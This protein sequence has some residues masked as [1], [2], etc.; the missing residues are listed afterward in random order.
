MKALL[1]KHVL[2]PFPD[3]T[4]PFNIYTDALDYQLN[5]VI[6][7]KGKPITYCSHKP[8]MPTVHH[9]YS[10]IVKDI[11]SIIKTLLEYH[12]KLYGE[13][14]APLVLRA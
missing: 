8:L 3:I 12:K 13:G 10:I 14:L 5:N 7:Q 2:L 11:L 1:S 4:K 9:H 6:M